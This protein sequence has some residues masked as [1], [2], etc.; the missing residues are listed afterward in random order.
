MGAIALP[1]LVVWQLAMARLQPTEE[2]KHTLFEEYE[3]VKIYLTA[4]GLHSWTLGSG[5]S[6][7]YVVSCLFGDVSIHVPCARPDPH[8]NHDCHLKVTLSRSI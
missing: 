2:T 8:P 1:N 7:R 4:F 3:T 5:E 6:A